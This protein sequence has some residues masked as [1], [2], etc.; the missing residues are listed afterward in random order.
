[1]PVVKGQEI[2]LTL[3]FAVAVDQLRIR[4][5]YS[6]QRHYI[7]SQNYIELPEHRSSKTTRRENIQSAVLFISTVVGILSTDCPSHTE[8]R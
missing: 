8:P 7:D 3:L 4:P 6:V 5:T 1:M 2:G